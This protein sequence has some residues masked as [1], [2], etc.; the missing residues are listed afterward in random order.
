MTLPNR[1]IRLK[2]EYADK[3]PACVS[4]AMQ[5]LDGGRPHNEDEEVGE[6]VTVSSS[7]ANDEILNVKIDV[8]TRLIGEGYTPDQARLIV[9]RAQ[10]T[11]AQEFVTDAAVL[12]DTLTQPSAPTEPAP[13][14]PLAAA[15]AE[16]SET[17]RRVETALGATPSLA[18]IIT[19]RLAH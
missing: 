11:T 16:T 15:L 10:G 6:E 1:P 7:D 17:V 5:P 4:D 8:L 13:V 18:D 14:G 3:D 19:D 2:V 12:A 9:E